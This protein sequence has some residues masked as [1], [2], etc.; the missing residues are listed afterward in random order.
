MQRTLLQI[1]QEIMSDLDSEDVNSI[2]DSVEAGQVASIVETTYRN[3]ITTREIPEHQ[4]LLKLT[5]LSDS[6]YPTHFEYPTNT[7][8]IDKIWY[9]NGDG[10]YQEVCFVEPMEFLD[11]TDTLQ[12]NYQTI[13][14]KN[15]GTKL[16][17]GNDADP[18]FYTTFDDKYIVMNSRDSS[19]DSTLQESKVRAWGTIYPTF[20]QSDSFVPDLDASYFPYLIAEAKSAA[21]S[22]LKGF[23][24]PKVEQ[25][26]RRQ[27]SFLQANKHNSS[28]GNKWSNYGR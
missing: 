23:S 20:T 22:L 26:A 9:E 11:R 19:E 3:M 7:K 14:D 18:T 1:V 17:V 12:S 27:K 21:G 6:A 10:D 15:G 16:R 28:R 8:S 24:D 13:T 25:A 4:Q 2:S 5:A